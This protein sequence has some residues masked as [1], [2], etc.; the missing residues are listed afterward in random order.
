MRVC[1]GFISNT[2]YAWWPNNAKCSFDVY[3]KHQKCLFISL[4]MNVIPCLASKD[5]RVLLL[6]FKIFFVV[7]FVFSKIQK[8]TMESLYSVAQAHH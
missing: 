6:S 5:K 2:W 7:F 3:Y 4:K 1:I 8:N